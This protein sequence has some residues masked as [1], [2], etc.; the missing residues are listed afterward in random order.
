LDLLREIRKLG[1]KTISTPI[2]SK[3]KLNTD[4]GEPIN[5]INQ[6]QRLVGEL[7]YLTVTRSDISFAI[8]QISQFMN[9]PQT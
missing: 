4:N 6:F 1:Y 8:S 2:D 9:S 3:V 5:N 7:I